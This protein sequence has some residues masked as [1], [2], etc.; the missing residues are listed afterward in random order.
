[1]T[2]GQTIQVNVVRRPEDAGPT[3]AIIPGEPVVIYSDACVRI[4][5]V[6]NDI[7][8]LHSYG[9]EAKDMIGITSCFLAHVRDCDYVQVPWGAPVNLEG[10]VD[11]PCGFWPQVSIV[12]PEGSAKLTW[13]GGQ[14]FGSGYYL[15]WDIDHWVLDT[16]TTSVDFDGEITESMDITL[17]PWPDGYT[18]ERTGPTK[19]YQ[20]KRLWQHSDICGNYH[21]TQMW[22]K[23]TCASVVE[24][25]TVGLND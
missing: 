21:H 12:T 13:A 16:P 14:Y 10:P 25:W 23:E 8:V 9:L 17:H 18:A 1:M 20:I 4:Y 2:A 15:Y 7:T 24:D 5:P 19:E 3:C 6:D 22:V 11:L